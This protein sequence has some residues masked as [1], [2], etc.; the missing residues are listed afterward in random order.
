MTPSPGTPVYRRALMRQIVSYGVVGAGGTLAH[1]VVLMALVEWDMLAPTPA[2]CTGFVVG[3]LINHELNR[4]IVFAATY[5]SR[6]TT[7]T[8][9]MLIAALGFLLN[10]AV[11]SLLADVFQVYYLLSQLLATLTVF[12]VTFAFNKTWTFQG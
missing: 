9:F 3:A 5:R 8:R 10:L 6:R 12:L 11:M 2:S 7:L 4:W 1:Y